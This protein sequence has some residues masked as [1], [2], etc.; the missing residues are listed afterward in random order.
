MLR[1]ALAVLALN[2][3]YLSHTPAEPPPPSDCEAAL[4]F[5]APAPMPG[6]CPTLANRAAFTMPDAAPEL[7]WTLE[8]PGEPPTYT[9]MAVA[10]RGRIYVQAGTQLVA[11]DDRGSS[12]S[13]AF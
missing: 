10:P 13:V 3:C 11:V 6:Y 7:R 8:L 12:G 4:L 1:F 5:G 2:G 9:G